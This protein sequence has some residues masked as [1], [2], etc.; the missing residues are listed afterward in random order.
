MVGVPCQTG[1]DGFEIMIDVKKHRL[2]TNADP[3]EV[4]KIN[5]ENEWQKR[6]GDLAGLKKKAKKNS[7]PRNP[8]KTKLRTSAHQLRAIRRD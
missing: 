4:E 8:K 6:L 1:R 2:E 7:G 3:R 5:E